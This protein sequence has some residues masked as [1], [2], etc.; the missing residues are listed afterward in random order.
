[1]VLPLDSAF[2]GDSTLPVGTT[3]DER[4]RASAVA[5]LPIGSFEQHGP[6]LPLTTDTLVAGAISRE[7]AAAHPVRL[8]P[9]ITISCSQEHVGWAGTVSISSQT[10]TAVIKDIC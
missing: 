4:G 5:L 10:L 2:M 1:M 7:I 8:L 3:V 6:Y 9:P